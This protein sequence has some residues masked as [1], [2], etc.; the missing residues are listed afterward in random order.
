MS[1]HELAGKPAPRELLV[2]VPRLVS[3][4]YTHKPDVGIRDQRVAFGTSGHRGSSLTHSFNEDHVLAICQAICEYRQ[5]TGHHR[6][7]CTW[8]WTP[9]PCPS[10]V[11]HRRGGTG[12]QRRGHHDPGRSRL[13]SHAGHLSRHP[14]LQSG[15]DIRPGRRRRHHALAQPAGRRRLQVQPAGSRPRRH[16]HHQNDPG[17][18]QRNPEGRAESSQAPALREG[19]QSSHHARVRLCRAVRGRSEQHHRYAR[20]S[21]R[22]ASRSA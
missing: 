22:P 1:A 18:R 9:T 11:R 3:A 4:Y 6:A 7:H 10:R 15:Q 14:D 8:V 19:A 12:R 21:P 17:P 20:P 16:R 2:N 13:H 5:V